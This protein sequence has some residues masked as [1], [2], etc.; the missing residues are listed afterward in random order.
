MSPGSFFENCRLNTFSV[1][2]SANDLIMLR[3]YTA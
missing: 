3:E 2:L 1:S